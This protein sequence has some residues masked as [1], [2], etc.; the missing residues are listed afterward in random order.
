M[1]PIWNSKHTTQGSFSLIL[2]ILMLLTPGFAVGQWANGQDARWVIGQTNLNAGDDNQGGSNPTATTL[3]DPQDIAIDAVN[4]KIYIADS[5]NHRVLRYTYP[6][7]ANNPQAEVVLGQPNFASGDANQGGSNPTAST[8]FSP[9][10]LALD[11]SGRLWV[12][13]FGN[14]RVLRFDDVINKA[15]GAAADG[16]LGQ[17]GFTTATVGADQDG[18]DA[19]GDV[20]VDGNGTLWVVDYGNNRV[21]RFDNAA[22]KSNG[23]D[24]DGVLGQPN[25]TSVTPPGSAS[26]SRMFEPSSVLAD[27]FGRLWVTDKQHDRILRF[28]DAVS[29][30]NGADADYVLGQPDFDTVITGT[31]ADKFDPAHLDFDERGNLYILGQSNN[32]RVTVFLGAL[33]DDSVDTATYVLGQENFLST[34]GGLGPDRL[35]MG[36]CCQALKV[37][38][39]N[40]ML[41]V[42]DFENNRVVGFEASEP[43]MYLQ[44]IP[45]FSTWGLLTLFLL[46]TVVGFVGLRLKMD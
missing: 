29:K 6:I 38:T 26:A 8:M 7:T 17:E 2:L 19:P 22:V 20:F 32:N 11:G 3:S 35:D 39:A 42:A 43:L 16:V 40:R 41:W 33:N 34:S 5:S 25:F 15:N 31:T 9:Y 36:S 14:N 10:G 30:P 1:L 18:L 13:E 4:G 12:V 24:A 46:M 44:A 21:L 27:D 37:D 45:T 23:A 28:D